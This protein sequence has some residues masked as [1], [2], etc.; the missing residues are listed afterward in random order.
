MMKN[1][2][3]TLL[4]ILTVLSC[5]Q[6]TEPKI[7]SKAEVKVI[8]KDTFLCTNGYDFPV[9]KPDSKG[10]YNAQKFT[11]NEHLGEDWNAVTGGDSDLGD[12]IFAIANGYVSFAENIQGGWGNIIRVVHHNNENDLVESLYAHCDTIYVKEKD[13][14][15]KGQQIGTIGNNDG[16]YL[17]HLHLE[18]RSTIG[19][20]VG[21]GY[22]SNTE[23]YLNP[24][25]Y[26]KNNRK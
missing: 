4:I 19:M 25:E 17:A 16:Q 10:Y 6:K 18:L 3:F 2:I 5:K 12:P 11:E 22:S 1:N 20:P 7:L 23:G 13:Y 9:G 24:T 21:G 26:I 14:V 8:K 15:T